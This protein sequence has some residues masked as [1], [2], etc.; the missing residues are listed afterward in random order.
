MN[1]FLTE[2]AKLELKK[3]KESNKDKNVD[4]R[5]VMSGISWGGPS[6][7]L[8]LDE[9][10][11]EDKKYDSEGFTFILSPSVERVLSYYP[12]LEVDYSKGLFSN[13]FRIRTN[14]LSA[15]C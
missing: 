15:C 4:F 2:N 12:E 5:I 10:N 7:K 13:G 14:R 11:K 8:V 1:I 9:P 6:F 3:L